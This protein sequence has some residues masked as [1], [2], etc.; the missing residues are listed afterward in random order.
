MT[1]NEYIKLAVVLLCFVW[2]NW[3]FIFRRKEFW[4]AVKGP[5]KVLQPAEA[6]IYVWVRLISI[7]I[8]GEEFYDYKLS[9][10]VWFS[11]DAILFGLIMGDVGN[12][13]L[14]KKIKNNDQLPRK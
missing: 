9:S 13:Y 6:C 12:K 14:D 8:L 7:I 3:D 5:D 11:L 1:E 10:E 2:V 4:E